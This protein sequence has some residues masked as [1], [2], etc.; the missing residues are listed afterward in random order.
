VRCAA[1]AGAECLGGSDLRTLPGFWRSLDDADDVFPCTDERPCAGDVASGAVS[2]GDATCNVGYHG[3]LCAICD[4]GYF[5][6]STGCTC[7]CL[8]GRRL[9]VATLAVAPAW[10]LQ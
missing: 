2:S 3:P 6:F 7:V 1:A 4:P 5:S 9:M 8:P 10:L